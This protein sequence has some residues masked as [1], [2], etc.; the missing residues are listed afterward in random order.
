[1]RKFLKRLEAL[2]AAAAFAEEGEVEAA[3]QTI[4]EAGGDERAAPATRAP[5][6]DRRPGNRRA[7]VRVARM[8]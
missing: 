3:R 8:P 2:F 7:P 1:V 4:A 5:A 6:A